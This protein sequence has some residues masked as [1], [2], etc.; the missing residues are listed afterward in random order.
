MS[1]TGRT[2]LMSGG[3]RGI[4]LAVAAAAAR[5]GANIVLLAKTDQAH[6]RL[7][8]TVHTA[9]AE[10]EEA[11]GQ[12]VAVVGDVRD[13]DS[14]SNAVAQAAARFGGIDI[15]VN[16]A[17]ALAVDGTDHLSMKQFDLMTQIQLRG[18]YL[19][20]SSA[21]PY[22]RAGT[23]PHVLSLSPP[24]NLSP[25]WLGAHPAYTTAKYG[26]TMLTLGW[27]EEYAERGIAANCLWPQTY[28]ATA[29]VKNVLG[30]DAALERARTPAIVADAAV[31]VL[32][33]SAATCTGNTFLDVDVLHE[34]GIT[35][36]TPYGGTRELEHDIFVDR[37]HDPPARED[38][39]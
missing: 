11:G 37:P 10:I 28:I 5:R 36:L 32:E 23:N 33:R 7:P 35:D 31:T 14:V 21:M 19:L 39:R 25:R 12:A 26:M 34:A 18:T 24:L 22:L 3:S 27:A 9:A 15:V 6:P 30:G 4:G 38:M 29:A 8:G 2:L 20:T 1:L 17:S 13:E 16:N